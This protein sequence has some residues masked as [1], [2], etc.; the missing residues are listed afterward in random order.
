MKSLLSAVAASR[1]VS[2][3]SILV[4]RRDLHLGFDGRRR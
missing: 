3:T 1:W 4:E 2:V